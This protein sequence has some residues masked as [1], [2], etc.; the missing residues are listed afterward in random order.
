MTLAAISPAKSQI[1]GCFQSVSSGSRG[2][3]VAA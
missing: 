1:S 2:F 3:L